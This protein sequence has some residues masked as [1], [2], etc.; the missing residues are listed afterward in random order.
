MTDREFFQRSLRL[1]EASRAHEK[2]REKECINLIASEGLKSPAAM[3][4]LHLCRDLE[5]RYCEGENDLEGHVKERHYQGQRFITQ[6][7]N[8][9][10]DLVKDIFRCSW[11]E[12]RPLSGTQANQVT[13]FGLSS[14]T[15]NSK[16]AAVPLS[17][18]AHISHD[19]TGLAGQVVGLEIINMTYDHEELNIAV[20][21]SVRIIKAARPGIVT[22]GGSLFQFPPPMEELAEAAREVGAFVVY[23][24]AH[25]LGLIAGGQFQQPLKEGADFVTG[26]THKT[27]PGP[28]GGLVFADLREPRQ[29][30]AA[31]EIQHAVFPLSTSNTHPG[32]F[33]ALAIAALELKLYG[34]QLAKQTVR[35]AQTAGECLFENG[36]KV[37]GEKHGFT[38]SHQIA[39]DVQEYGGGAR[40]AKNLEKANIIINKNLLPYDSQSDR[41]RPSG[42]RLG[43]QEVTRRGFRESDVKH[44]C[45]LILD[46]VKGRRDPRLVRKEVMELR[47][48][49][50]GIR[51]GFKSLEE[52]ENRLRKKLGLV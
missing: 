49:F 30:D 45:S 3:E 16:M 18:G 47:Q 40:V 52:V 8:L 13:F 26:S 41:A 21:E 17:A 6:I 22:L 2:Y 43:F 42:I 48:S 37:L 35:N 34:D 46:V 15:N 5:A 4:M 36:L 32:R 10:A 33:P 7:E 1:I 31:R 9:T 50:Q 51:Y 28:Q 27:F 39:V 12:I 11:V 23:D 29:R 38:Q 19:Y 24:A 14:L 20:D 44:L 25:V